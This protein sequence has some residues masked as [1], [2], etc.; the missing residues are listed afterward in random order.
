M[1]LPVLYEADPHDL[2]AA[3]GG[4][5]DRVGELAQPRLYAVAVALTILV[6]AGR[7]TTWPSWNSAPPG[8]AK[9]FGRRDVVWAMWQLFGAPTE[10]LVRAGSNVDMQLH[11]PQRVLLDV[12]YGA[13]G[14]LTLVAPKPIENR[15]DSVKL[16]LDNPSWVWSDRTTGS[17][18]SPTTIAEYNPVNSI[19]QQN[20]IGC[21]FPTARA[22]EQNPDNPGSVY[23]VLRAQCPQ[24]R[25][26]VGGEPR[27]SLNDDVCGGQGDSR[28]RATTK[29]RLLAPPMA[30]SD[31]YLV[32]PDSIIQ[33]VG[34]ATAGAHLLP[35]ASDLSLLV[36]WCHT[37]G[38]GVQDATR[39]P[40]LLGADG[41][42]LLTS[43]A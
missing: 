33:L 17:T 11:Q 18:A 40:G 16:T 7:A 24:R 36:S 43:P 12:L 3:I 23:A 42:R 13:N 21:A 25:A 26:V 29:P 28:E 6:R 34:L 4:I 19:N 31:A 27:C 9:R 5:R 41:I 39:L 30:D 38:S 2:R 10:A 35:A 1:S 14:P 22:I 15:R 37:G 8:S 20:G 32:L